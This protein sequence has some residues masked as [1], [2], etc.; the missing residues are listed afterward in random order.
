VSPIVPKVAAKASVVS[1]G[2]MTA[3]SSY[4]ET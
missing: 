1:R 4:G 3:L 2:S